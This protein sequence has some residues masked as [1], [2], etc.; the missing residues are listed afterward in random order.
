MYKFINGKKVY[1]VGEIDERVEPLE[2]TVAE[3]YEAAT[4]ALDTANTIAPTANEALATANAAKAKADEH[5]TAI[6]N[7]TATATNAASI[8]TAAK[9]TAEAVDAK[10][11][12]ANNTANDALALAKNHIFYVTALPTN[13]ENAVYVIKNG[14]SYTDLTAGNVVYVDA[15]Y[16]G[17]KINNTF[18]Q[19]LPFSYIL[20]TTVQRSM[21]GVS[22]ATLDA[23]HRIPMSQM[24]TN[25]TLYLGNWDASTGQ[26]PSSEGVTNGDWYLVE[27]AGDVGTIHFDVNDRIMWNGT[28]W[29]KQFNTEGVTSV[30]GMTGAVTIE[31][32]PVID[33][34]TST[35]MD[36]A[37]SANQGK[38]LQDSK[39]DVFGSNITVTGAQFIPSKIP[40]NDDAAIEDTNTIIDCKVS[41][42]GVLV[43]TFRKSFSKLWD[44]INSKIS[45][46]GYTK[47]T[48]TVT[49]VTMNGAAKPV[50]DGVV[51][52]GTV[53]TSEAY[54]GT[55]TSVSI[56]MNGS[57]KGTVTGS[58]TIDLGTVMTSYR[59]PTSQPSSPTAGDV[60]LII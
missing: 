15:M 39:V 36:K 50:T 42:D 27:V 58:G 51:D 26:Y 52:L 35:D 19:Y 59:V 11:T 3:A 40:Q 16:I 34:L 37:L 30:N 46:A 57:T 24:P 25:A 6:T 14:A 28:A 60:W 31:E 55:V 47:N 2:T 41:E 38:V 56:K 48:G 5:D 53:L 20:N 23:N 18:T 10:A 9:T 8:A 13:A 49:G 43:S 32:T 17:D 33:N 29:V 44:W 21:L 7:V 54:R 4:E 1:E 45:A 12:E 22:V